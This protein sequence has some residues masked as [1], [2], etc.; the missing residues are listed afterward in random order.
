M[1]PEGL[2]AGAAA[3]RAVSDAA[4]GDVD[5]LRRHLGFFSGA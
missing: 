1:L 4:R 2:S 5:P 3:V